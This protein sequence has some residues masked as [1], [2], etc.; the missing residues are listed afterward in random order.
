MGFQG[1]EFAIRS[2]F[3]IHCFGAA[4]GSG[5]GCCYVGTVTGVGAGVGVG[6]GAGAGAVG[7]RKRGA[8]GD[9]GL[10][11]GLVIQS[12]IGRI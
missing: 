12:P 8:F 2:T 5:V 7:L 1:C 11:L 6:A 3:G 4:G 10:G 9:G